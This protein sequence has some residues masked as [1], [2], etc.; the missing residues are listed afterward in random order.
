VPTFAGRS[1]R[2]FSI[3]RDAFW[4][5]ALGV[6]VAYGFF[7]ALGAFSAGEVLPLTIVMGV[8]AALWLLHAWTSSRREASR[9]PGLTDARE[10]RGF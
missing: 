10:R 6:L 1:G 4:V 7:L 2:T 8:L 9:D 3:A 5:L